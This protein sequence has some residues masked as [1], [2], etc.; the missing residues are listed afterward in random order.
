MRRGRVTRWRAFSTGLWCRGRPMTPS[1][2]P[3]TPRAVSWPAAP[4]SACFISAHSATCRSSPALISFSRRWKPPT[5][6]C[7]RGCSTIPSR[8]RTPTATCSRLCGHGR[9]SW[10]APIPTSWSSAATHWSIAPARW[11]T[12]TWRWAAKCSIAASR[13]RRS[14]GMRWPRQLRRAAGRGAARAR[15]GDRRFGRTDLKGAAALGIDSLFV[16]SGIHAEEYGGRHTPEIEALDGIF[17]AGGVTPMAVT[18][19]LKW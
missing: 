6:W 16:T 18:R 15:A 19:G 12:P 14:I 8:R 5:T 3:A 13:I 17:A 2:A 11:P 4:A 10:S 1:P 7:A 9:Y